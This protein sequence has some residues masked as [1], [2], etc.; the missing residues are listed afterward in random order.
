[1]IVLSS[2]ADPISPQNFLKIACFFEGGLI[3]IAFLIAWAVDI[4]PL[5][6]LSFGGNAIFWGMLGTIPLYL[7]FLLFY[8]YPLGPFYPIKR[9]LI[10]ILGPMLADAGPKQLLLLAIMAGFSE[11]LL[12]R[13]VLQPWL[14]FNW[15]MTLGLIFSNLIFGFLHW[16]TPMYAL[17]AG[18]VGVY[19]G[20]MLD[21][22]GERNLLTPVVIHAVYDYLAFLVVAQGYLEEQGTE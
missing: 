12:F 7:L 21:A 18:I 14:Q 8:N 9:A 10:D 4:H 15:G 6:H 20:L 3:G 22:G 13:G 2:P 19:L 17:I 11:E 5:A 16:V 1:M